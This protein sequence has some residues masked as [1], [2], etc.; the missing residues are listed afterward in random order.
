[1]AIPR[2]TREELKARLDSPD[3][4]SRPIIVDVRLKYPYE[5][6]TVTLPGAQRV[7]P[8]AMADA[9]LPT[10]REIVLFDSDPDDIVS[11]QAG[12][13]LVRRGY[14][15]LV[16]QGGISEWMNAKLPVDTKSAP[17]PAAPAAKAAA[18]AGAKPAGAPPAPAAKPTAPASQ[19]TARAA[20]AEPNPA[21]PAASSVA[22]AAPKSENPASVEGP[23]TPA[24]EA[25]RSGS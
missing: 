7:L 22:A 19:A 14:R 25:E 16:L 11:M 13:E 18:P 20:G 12:A 23:A 2:I 6:S 9:S 24:T 1:M 3:A 5:H 21:P 17:Q 8:D 4:S 15:V 10:D